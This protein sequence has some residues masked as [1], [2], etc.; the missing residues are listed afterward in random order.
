M[1][2]PR[3]ESSAGCIRAL[4][5]SLIQQRP[6]DRT[7]QEHFTDAKDVHL[8]LVRRNWEQWLDSH[9][10]VLLI[11]LDRYACVRAKLL[12]SYPTLC[13]PMDCSPPDSSF[14]GILQARILEGVA[15][16][17][18]RGSSL[19]RDQT[20]VS[21]G[22]CNAGRFF[23]TEPPGKPLIDPIQ[24]KKFFTKSRTAAFS[25]PFPSHCD[26]HQI[27]HTFW[28][29]RQALPLGENTAISCWKPPWVSALRLLSEDAKLNFSQ[30][31]QNW[32]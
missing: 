8:S 15:M 28:K 24:N 4:Q 20:R 7:R 18:S 12:Q 10:W 21:S 31:L 19:P 32:Y 3:A 5:R 17:S 30:D 2:Y 9:H 25:N 27:S 26:N 16:P 1:F 14:H 22:P 29:G 11:H 23:T 6:Q 13:N